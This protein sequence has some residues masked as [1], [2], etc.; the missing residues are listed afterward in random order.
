MAEL[1]DL[2]ART[3][4]INAYC[5]QTLWPQIEEVDRQFKVDT[6][7]LKTKFKHGGPLILIGWIL[8]MFTKNPHGS[9][10]AAIF[11]IGAAIG[12]IGFLYVFAELSKAMRLFGKRAV[13]MR[14]LTIKIKK[15]LVKFLD[16]TFAF[17]PNCEFPK[18]VYHSSGLF[19]TSYDRASADDKLTGILGKTKFLSMK[20]AT[21]KKTTRRNSRG[22]STI[23]WQPVYR[24]LFFQADFNKNFSGQT[25]VRTDASEKVVG[26]I[27]RTAQRLK[28]AFSNSRLVE[29]EDPVFEAEFQV[30]STDPTQARYILTPAFME[31]ILELKQKHQTEIQLAF[32]NS[33]VV[34][35]IARIEPHNDMQTV[36]NGLTGTN[37]FDLNNLTTSAQQ[38]LAEIFL[39]LE[40]IEDL[41]LNNRIAKAS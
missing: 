15:S 37:R 35:G 5:Q 27:A 24:G 22:K 2:R 33:K 38:L 30:H 10:Q 17:E 34:V 7:T 23:E 28:T 9:L 1:S 13:A 11:T 14:E 8:T 19:P 21:Y 16:P 29:L 39:V 26:G 6:S 36:L 12:L 25:T 18:A 41:D 31:R 4:E 40:L 20:I 3:T 32:L